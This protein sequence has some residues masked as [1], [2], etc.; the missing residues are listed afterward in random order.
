MAAEPFHPW[1]AK[2]FEKE[3]GYPF[4]YIELEIH[5]AVQS[6]VDTF[7]HMSAW[8]EGNKGWAGNRATYYS[9]EVES[10][11]GLAADFCSDML[12]GSFVG[13]SLVLGASFAPSIHDEQNDLVLFYQTW[14]N[15][16]SLLFSITHYED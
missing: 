9:S 5:F 15:I 13:V 11:M 10:D 8:T 12:E 1:A 6:P 4:A 7:D 14:A 2:G 3:T 16:S